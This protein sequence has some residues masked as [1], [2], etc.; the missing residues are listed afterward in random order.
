[1]NIEEIVKNSH[2]YREC[3]R[4]INWNVTGSSYVKIKKIINDLNLDTSHFKVIQDGINKGKTY[5]SVEIFIENSDFSRKN[6]KNRIIKENLMEYKCKMCGND[7]NW[8]GKKF[9][10]V[11]DHINGI[12]NDNRIEN[13]RFLC[14]N[15]NATTETFCGKN[16]K[17]SKYNNDLHFCSCGNMIY[18]KSSK[19]CFECSK[20]KQRHTKRPS[21][22]VLIKNIKELGYRGTGKLYNVSDNSI[23]KWMNYYK[24]RDISDSNR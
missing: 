6:L 12:N 5:T 14:P 21:Y 2:S 3:I 22:D 23:R 11:L 15:C 1:M 8:M 24:K 9:S 20:I 19:N 10:L 17:N 4:K 13:L 18:S 7:G 16:K